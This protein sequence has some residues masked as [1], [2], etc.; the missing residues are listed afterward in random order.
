MLAVL[1]ALSA[2]AAYGVSDFIGGVASRRS[3]AWPVAL[4]GAVGALLGA[5]LLGV[6]RPG[7]PSGT[8][9]AWGALAGVGSG[10]GGAFLYRGFAAGRMGVVAPV[11]AVGAALVPIAVGVI[12]GERP[13]S[14]V[15][16]GIAAAIPGIWL[17]SREPGNDAGLAAGLF[18]GVLAGLGFGVLFAAIG[19]VR[20]DAGIWPLALCQLVALLS[21]ATTATLLRERWWPYERS[22]SLGLAAGLL[23]TAAAFAFLLASQ[24][25]FLTVAAVLTA[26]YPAVTIVLAAGILRER[27]DRLQAVGL[28]LCGLTVALVAAG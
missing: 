16:C 27:V 18:D 9:F 26:L 12:S 1:L 5:V 20:E 4:L 19:Q 22:Q 17:V 25:G 10:T 2:A 13:G 6:V 8:D 14:L 3:S 21:V 15:W 23:A 28:V 11:S 24:T 7:D